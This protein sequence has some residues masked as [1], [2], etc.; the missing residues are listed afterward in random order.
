ML[1]G[2]TISNVLE[3]NSQA[4]FAWFLAGRLEW[5]I[6][7]ICGDAYQ[8]E[9]ILDIT[10]VRSWIH[11]LINSKIEI[12]DGHESG[13]QI[14]L[15]TSYTYLTVFEYHRKCLISIFTQTVTV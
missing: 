13:S 5:E 11:C 4:S 1:S 6:V 10:D 15:R 14:E 12:N 8:M 9:G 3:K 2:T 7:V